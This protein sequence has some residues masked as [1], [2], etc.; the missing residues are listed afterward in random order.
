MMPE[1]KYAKEEPHVDDFDMIRI[2]C[3]SPEQILKWSHG[4]VTKP[5]TINYR[6]QKAE[7][8]GLFDERI[9]GPERDFECYCG[10]YKKIRYKGIICDKCGVEVTRSLVRRE[11]MGHISLAVPVTHIWYLRGVPSR[12]SLVS[13]MPV[14]DLERV[15]YFGAFVVTAVDEKK[16]Q[17]VLEKLQKDFE[18]Y[19]KS[20]D[21]EFSARIAEAEKKLE[22]I[23]KGDDKKYVK[24]VEQVESEKSKLAAQKEAK[25]QE[26]AQVHQ[27]AVSEVKNL[28][29]KRVISEAKLL[30]FSEKYGEFFKVGIGAEAI[31]D[32]VKKIDIDEEIKNLNKEYEEALGQK[33]R[34][35]ARR[36]QFLLGLKKA[37]I[38]PAWMIIKEL[39]VIPPD[40]RPMVQLDG[41]RFAASDLN[42]LY[43]RVINRNNRLKRLR[44]LGAP[45]VIQRNE[46][47]MLQEAVDALID[48][49][50]RKGK[51]VTTATNKRRLKSL[52][53][54]LR[55]KQG[56]F[57][58]NL[59]GK[60]V[61]YSGRS[62]IVVGPDL[63]LDQCGL[64]KKMVLE[65][66]KPFV[67]GGLIRK[68]YTHNVK[69]AAR[70]IERS[71]PEVWEVLEEVIADKLVLLN[72][73]PTLHRLGIQAFRPVLIEGKAIQIHPLVCTAFN[74]DF[75]GDQMAVHVPLSDAAQKEAREIML[76]T[77]NLLKPADGAPVVFVTRDIVIGIYF[78]TCEKEVARGDGKIF[79]TAEEVENAYNLGLVEV[80]AK[81]KFKLPAEKVRDKAVVDTT[82]G[83][84]LF[85][86]I[87]P[88]DFD[89][90][91][92]VMDSKSLKKL[93]G[94]VLEKYGEEA[95]AR[96][97]DEMKNLGFKHSTYSGLTFSVY[98]IKIPESKKEIIAEAEKRADEIDK[99]YARGL[100]TDFERHVSMVTI[101]RRASSEIEKVILDAQEKNGPIYIMIASGARGSVNQLSQMS[102]M[103][104]LVV[105][106]A[107]EVIELPIKSNFR[108]GLT[109]LEYFISTHGARKGR[110]DTALRTADAGYLTRRLV[111]VCQDTII[112]E[113]DCGT[114][115]FVTIT[116]EET[117]MI[118][119]SFA[120]RVRGRVLAE[121]VLVQG[122]VIYKKG[123]EVDSK[124]ALELE[125]NEAV[126]AVAV[127]SPLVCETSFGICQRCYGWDLARNRLVELG[128]AVG[129]MAA[130][131]I[132]EPGTQLTM[133]TFHTGGVIG[134][135]I[136]Q[137]LPRVEELFEAR[138]PKEPAPL[139][140]ISGRVKIKE[141]NGE[142]VVAIE[143]KEPQRIELRI[144]E[145]YNILVKDGAS[146]SVKQALASAANKPT[147]RATIP[148]TVKVSAKKILLSGENKITKLYPVLPQVNVLVVEGQMVERGQP[149]TEGHIAV[150]DLMTLA[151]PM[152]VK[153]YL[154]N[155]VQQIYASQG[156]V[157]NDKHIEIV[158]RQMF[159]KCRIKE[160]GDSGYFPGMIVERLPL[161]KMNKELK[162][163][164]KKPA[165]AEELLLGVTKAALKTESFLSAASFQETTS[166]LVEAAVQGKVDKLRGLKENTIIGRLI[167]AGTGF[168]KMD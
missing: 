124:I 90:I 160:A 60:R 23:D 12:L 111:D 70:M 61:D 150:Q 64:P 56:R 71:L 147:I 30:D 134:K 66:F 129:V 39:P 78:L 46:K 6:T 136:T 79:A 105:N 67:I 94:K 62:V 33:K 21:E 81:I 142:K 38:E 47:R 100:I 25:R 14:R 154:V 140:E 18:A 58:Q 76:S 86:Q 133:R 166:V 40:L 45:E 103:K 44:E 28:S 102:G 158:V 125:N 75:D 4:E 80:Q 7:K 84:V 87:L 162:A 107:G 41:G 97:A 54:M 93:L 72:R 13:D 29:V 135:D 8:D 137:G 151:G 24:L 53:D 59:L 88:P 167:P 132:G 144:P 63:K 156:Q 82:V 52:S 127:R 101:W 153:K 16:R 106:P 69:S 121:A 5:E 20:L 35:I 112:S 91:N 50:A 123:T 48:N 149:L 17:A 73:A 31:L 143:A 74:A 145:G 68:G 89:F 138:T 95:A 26:L 116:K 15:A 130:Q 157:I 148:G 168:R 27:I 11:R 96:F 55:G 36:L 49:A 37:G 3:A 92:T 164:G 109:E 9:F 108:E 117:E 22:E 128:T 141:Q 19:Q 77:K 10:K 65:L 161:E 118:G 42:D 165:E 51:E 2:S 163:K 83:R 32:I 1:K 34:K 126:L 115:N 139:A 114:K 57:R 120:D 152:S 104:G 146:V 131:S 110:S 113:E 43:R 155:E 99:Q 159:S 85:N 98:D 119:E 122:K